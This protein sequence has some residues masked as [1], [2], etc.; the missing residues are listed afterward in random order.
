[1]PWEQDGEERS[2]RQQDEGKMDGG[3]CPSLTFIA[4]GGQPPA[5]MTSLHHDP[6]HAALTNQVE[7]LPK[8]HGEAESPTSNQSPLIIKAAGS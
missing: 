7:Q 5:S 2:R 1:M 4:K 8:K 6:L 3:L